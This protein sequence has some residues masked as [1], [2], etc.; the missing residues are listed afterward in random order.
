MTKVK[1][2]NCG[3][4]YG[5]RRRVKNSCVF[6]TKNKKLFYFLLKQINFFILIIISPQDF[7]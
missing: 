1:K 4:K 5:R 6:L 3:K 2:K 7:V